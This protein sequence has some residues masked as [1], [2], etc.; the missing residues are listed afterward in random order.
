ME[1]LT[2]E[3]KKI[4]IDKGTE[5]P[6]SGKYD[7]FWENGV[8]VCRQCGAPLYKSE[9]KFDA[10]CGWPSFDT[11]ISGAVT[12]TLDPDGMR[13]EITCNHCAG[14]LGHVFIGEQLT[15]KNTRHCVNSA[16]LK[17]ISADEIAEKKDKEQFVKYFLI[18]NWVELQ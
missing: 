10:R 12:R 2:P 16:S 15:E 6:F 11:E 9:D 4:I 1:P 3:E 7:D 8:Y 17:F 14:H 13:T 18:D 5:M